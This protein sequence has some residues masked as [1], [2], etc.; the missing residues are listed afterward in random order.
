V[1]IY[2]EVSKMIVSLIINEYLNGRV[3]ITTDRL[4]GFRTGNGSQPAGFWENL[5]KWVAQKNKNE[6]VNLC[7]VKSSN[8]FHNEFLSKIEDINYQEFNENEIFSIN[9]D[10]F[11]LLYFVGLPKI[12][13]PDDLPET[14]EEYVRN[15]GGLIVESPDIIGDIEIVSLIDPVSV[16]SNKRPSY[17]AAY[18]TQFG[19]ESEVY[20]KENTSSSFMVEIRS[21]DFSENWDIILSNVETSVGKVETGAAIASNDYSSRSFQEFGVGFIVGISDGTVLLEEGDH[22]LSSS[23]S[24]S[25]SSTVDEVY[26]D[27]CDNILGYWKLNEANTNSFVWDS[28]GNFSQIGDFRSGGLSSYTVDNSISGKINNAL[29][30]SE[31]GMNNVLIPPGVNLNFKD[32]LIDSAFSIFLWVKPYDDIGTRYLISKENVWDLFLTNNYIN[33][34]LIDGLNTR[35]VSSSSTVVV[36]QWNLITVIYDGSLGSIYINNTDVTDSQVDIG[37]SSMSDLSTSLYIGSS[38]SGDWFEGGIDNVLILDKPAD[39]VELEG[40]WNMGIGTENCS[41]TVKYTSSSSSSST[42]NSSS[43]SSSSSSAI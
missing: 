3:A 8:I 35:T 38:P 32:G 40:L 5:I 4:G 34:K 14:I 43:S 29:Y 39:I 10:D 24:S 23:S 11:D 1:K 19:L 27:L 9:F 6:N 13:A 21:T 18:W 15:G 7:I 41:D 36:N 16:T 20:Y 26:W 31:I 17:E 42:S 28:S 2:Y 12:G 30:F 37:Y 25:S 33:L 22:A